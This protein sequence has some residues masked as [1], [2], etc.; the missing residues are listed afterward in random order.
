MATGA[1][2]TPALFGADGNQTVRVAGYLLLACVLMVLDHRTGALDRVHAALSRLTGPVY[3]LAAAPNRAAQQMVDVVAERQALLRENADL[4]QALLLAEARI[5]RFGAVAE[6]NARLRA[7]LG[8]SERYGLKGQ[9]AELVDIDLDPFRHRLLLNAGTEAGIENG[10]A[11]IDGSGVMGQVVDA[12]VGRATL[13]LVTDPNHALPVTLSRTGLRTIAFGTGSTAALRLPH[14]PFSADIAVGDVLV[15]SGLGGRF[16]AGLPVG[17]VSALG[18]DDSGTFIRAT[19]VPAAG[20]ARSGEV[21]V[22][23]QVPEDIGAPAMPDDAGSQ[24]LV[25]PPAPP[26]SPP[27]DPQGDPPATSAAAES[28]AAPDTA[29]IESPPR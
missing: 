23:K 13:L 3:W 1:S 19:A 15:T 28:S 25:G 26:A 29:A 10:Q 7:L 18:P 21:L 22:L 11:V 27:L 9:L 2:A 17:V 5:G 24:I 8:V 16:P 12:D 4:K 20:L 6:Q 14:V